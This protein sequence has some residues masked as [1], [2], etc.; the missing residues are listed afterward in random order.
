MATVV[1]KCVEYNL[2]VNG[3]KFAIEHLQIWDKH[4]PLIKR[5]ETKINGV[6]KYTSHPNRWRTT[7]PTKK[8]M[9]KHLELY[10]SRYF[11]WEIRNIDGKIICVKD[12]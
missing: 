7:M 2:E 3:R 12:L 6:P 8:E 1:T 4:Y 5:W 9:V 10:D 11:S